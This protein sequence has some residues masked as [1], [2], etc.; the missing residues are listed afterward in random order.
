VDSILLPS[1]KIKENYNTLAVE[2]KAGQVYTGIKVRETKDELVLRNTDDKEIVLRTR[3][4]EEKLNVPTSLMPEGLADGLTRAELV[5]LVR[6][7]SELGKVGPYSVGQARVVRRW[8]TLDATNEVGNLLRR[9][10]IAAAAGNHPT[11]TWS[12]AYSVVSGSLPIDDLPKTRIWG[13]T[14]F[15][16]VV[17]C[18]LDVTTPG[19]AKLRFNSAKELM[20]WL[21]GNPLDAK[22]EVVL[23][24]TT[25]LHTLT[26]AIDR[27]KRK[28]ALRCELEDVAGSPA[29][30]R[31]IGGK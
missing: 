28:E 18:Q 27:D 24:L 12:P 31:L 10:R 9:E 16:S 6:F 11:L 20:L 21:D 1:K 17:R 13:G 3:D 7:L 15:L 25:G 14:P 30:V 8:Q 2:T 4:I 22:D 26:V 5:D 29:R 23:D 19:Q